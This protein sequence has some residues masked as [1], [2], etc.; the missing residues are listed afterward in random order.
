MQVQSEE[1]GEEPMVAGPLRRQTIDSLLCLTSESERRSRSAPANP[2]VSWIASSNCRTGNNPAS[3]VIFA[4][5][6]STSM[7]FCGRK[8]KTN[9]NTPCK[10]IGG[11]PAACKC[12]SHKHFYTEEGHFVKW[13]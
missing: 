6:T 9:G 4:A 7:R 1:I 3:L 13:Q 8:S 11:L 12:P 2:A 5:E 10:L